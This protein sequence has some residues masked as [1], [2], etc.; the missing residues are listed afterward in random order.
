MCECEDRPKTFKE[1]SKESIEDKFYLNLFH[2]FPDFFR[3]VYDSIC[4]LD[5]DDKFYH[6][7][8]ETIH[9]M[10]KNIILACLEQ[11]FDNAIDLQNRYDVSSGNK[12]RREE[13]SKNSQ[14]EKE[15]AYFSPD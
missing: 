1:E 15:F 12:K 9:R 7:Q 8:A 6:S 3:S 5:I 14:D 2:T 13:K 11:S 10:A 4:A